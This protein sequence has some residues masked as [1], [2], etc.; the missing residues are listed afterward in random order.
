MFKNFNKIKYN[1]GMTLIELLVVISIF[2]ILTSMTIFDYGSFRSSISIKNLADDIALSI[3]KAQSYAIG[4]HSDS[5]FSSGYGVHF[6]TSTNSSDPLL[7]GSNKSFVIFNDLGPHDTAYNYPLNGPCG[8]GSE[9]NEVLNIITA[10]KISEIYINDTKVDT[11]SS[12]DISFLRPNPDAYF[13]YRSD[14]SSSTCNTSYSPIS[15]V[16]IVVSN[17]QSDKTQTI[18]LWNTGQISVQ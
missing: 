9:C 16:K 2:V 6:T 4:V 8:N 15:H 11:G 12:I 1:G 18:T 13:C 14:N 10:D 7:S 5:N 3:R 17:S